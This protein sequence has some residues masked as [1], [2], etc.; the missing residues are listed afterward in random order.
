[1]PRPFRGVGQL[2]FALLKGDARRTVS[3]WS[4]TAALGGNPVLLSL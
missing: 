1:M 2:L 3:S 4:G